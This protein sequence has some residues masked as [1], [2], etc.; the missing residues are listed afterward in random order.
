MKKAIKLWIAMSVVC[1]AFSAAFTE[2]IVGGTGPSS[3][4]LN[5]GSTLSSVI[6]DIIGIFNLLVPLLIGAAV[7][8]FLYGIVVFIAKQSA[9]DA[10]GRKEGLNFMIFGIIGIA[11]M[12]SVWGLVAFVTNTLGTSSSAIPQLNSNAQ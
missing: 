2:A 5:S 12:V 11:V 7:V 3:G 6:N 4:L 1:Y 10:E 8:V 9:G